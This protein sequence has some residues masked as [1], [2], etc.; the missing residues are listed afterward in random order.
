MLLPTST[1]YHL[2]LSTTYDYYLRLLLTAYYFYLLL[3]L[4]GHGAARGGHGRRAGLTY[5]WDSLL[6][7]SRT[8]LRALEMIGAWG[9]AGVTV[10]CSRSVVGVQWRRCYANAMLVERT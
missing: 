2:L 7:D 6:T 8:V 3:T 5:T 1:Y 10:Q 9:D 4:G